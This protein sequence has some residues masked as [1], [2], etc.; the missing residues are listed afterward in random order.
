MAHGTNRFATIDVTENVDTLFDT[1]EPEQLATVREM[2]QAH[3]FDRD[4][5]IQLSP[6]LASPSHRT[7]VALRLFYFVARRSG[8]D[9]ENDWIELIVGERDTISDANEALVHA[10]LR[11]IAEDVTRAA[12]RG[13]ERL[14]AAR[15]SHPGAAEAARVVEHIWRG[16][17]RGAEQLERWLDTQSS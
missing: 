7:L 10:S 1:L 5:A 8:A 14:E 17:L 9:S 11:A 3:D 13:L 15:G 4:Y 6:P 2:L 12:R 16:H